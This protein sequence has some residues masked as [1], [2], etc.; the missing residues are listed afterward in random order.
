MRVVVYVVELIGFYWREPLVRTDAQVNAC[1][2][3]AYF[4]SD[5]V[6]AR[7][8]EKIEPA[9][10]TKSGLELEG[11]KQ[12]KGARRWDRSSMSMHAC[13]RTSASEKQ[14]HTRVYVSSS[15]QLAPPEINYNYVRA[16][17]RERDT[18]GRVIYLTRVY[19]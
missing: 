18:Y 17:A 15:I 8:N 7:S 5:H 9:I 19:R 12:T 11:K 13:V 3:G 6:R 4:R 1:T 16:Y 10:Y 2:L 14:T